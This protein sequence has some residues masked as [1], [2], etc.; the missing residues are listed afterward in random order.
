MEQLQS[1]LRAYN[2]SH[3]EELIFAPWSK[4]YCENIFPKYWEIVYSLLTG[5]NRNSLV[6]EIGCGLGDVT[7]ILCYLKFVHIMSFEKDDRISSLAQKRMYEM[8]GRR[9][10]IRNEEF[11]NGHQYSADVLI[12]V[13]CAY[14]NLVQTKQEYMDLMRKY[15]VSAGR[16]KYYL[17][18]VIDSSY[19]KVDD[20]FPEHIRLSCS[21]IAKFFP[22]S[23]IT[24][25]QTYKYPVNKKSKTLY[26]I[27]RI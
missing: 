4:Q 16:P 10:I 18:E 9:D 17:M 2:L 8:F 1:L 20:E 22:D 13:N 23:D 24:S 25:W 15:Y 21:D 5:L 12:L 26:L 11:P 6:I 14:G 19:T 7:A 3:K 27:R